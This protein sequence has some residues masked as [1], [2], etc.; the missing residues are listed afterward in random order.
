MIFW[1][2]HFEGFLA[3]IGLETGLRVSVSFPVSTGLMVGLISYL[4]PIGSCITQLEDQRP[5][6]TCDES[7]E[8]YEGVFA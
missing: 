1:P 2:K 5:S 8:E 7:I 3:M 4:R 6:R